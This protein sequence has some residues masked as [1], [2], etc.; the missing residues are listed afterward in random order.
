MIIS[1]LPPS[2]HFISP[3]LYRYY[4]K[5]ADR[6]KER[7][8]AIYDSILKDHVALDDGAFKWLLTGLGKSCSPAKSFGKV[9][10]LLS[11]MISFGI[12]PDAATWR[13]GLNS[14]VVKLSLTVVV[15]PL[16]NSVKL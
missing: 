11:R 13:T 15:K 4:S 3:A 9:D 6:A 5:D 10:L 12:S 2:H 1:N 8:N 7:I 16:S 14:K